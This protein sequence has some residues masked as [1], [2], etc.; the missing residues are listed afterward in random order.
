MSETPADMLKRLIFERT[1]IKS[2]NLVCPRETSDMTP[3]V[4]RDGQL[5]VGQKF[6][7]EICV[8]CEWDVLGLL[9]RERSK[10]EGKVT[11]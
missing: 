4:A 2:S 5:A 3:C 11:G 1:G 9:E 8:G 10:M 7:E 6:S